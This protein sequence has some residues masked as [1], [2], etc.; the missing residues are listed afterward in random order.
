MIR[1]L[2]PALAIALPTS[3]LLL[4]A[5]GSPPPARQAGGGQPA[6]TLVDPAALYCAGTGGTVIPATAGG[7]RAD[8]CRMPDGRTVRAADLLNSHNDL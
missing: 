2:S 5:C 8:L 6:A 1:C 7:R 4:A 3:L